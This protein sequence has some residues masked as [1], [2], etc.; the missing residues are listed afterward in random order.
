MAI[1]PLFIFKHKT[2]VQYLLCFIVACV[3]STVITAQPPFSFGIK[4]GKMTITASKNLTQKQIDS[5]SFKYKLSELK[6]DLLIKQNFTDSLKN[7]GW[8]VEKND[9]KW[10][11]LS[12]N[13]ESTEL[14]VGHGKEPFITPTLKNNNPFLFFNKYLLNRFKKNK[15]PT[16]TDTTITLTYKPVKTA[17]E[18][19]LAGSFTNW[20]RNAIPMVKQQNNEFSITVPLSKGKHTYKFIVDGEWTV[21]PLNEQVQDDGEGN[22]NSLLCKSNVSFYLPGYLKAK[23]VFLAG[24]FNNWQDQYI[25]LIKKDSGWF[26]NMYLIDGNYTYKFIVDDQWIEDPNNPMKYPNEFYG[27]YNSV[28]QIGTPTTFSLNGFLNAKKVTLLGSFNNFR[29]YEVVLEKNKEG[30]FTSYVIENG[31]H[32]YG[33]KVDNS[34][35]NQQGEIINNIEEGGTALVINANHSFTLKGFEKAKKI[36]VAGNFNGWKK[37]ATAMKFLNGVWSAEVYLPPGK[38]LYKFIVDGNWIKDP[39]N[40]LWE[41]NEYGDGN[42]IIWKE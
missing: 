33:F 41:G 25:K 17:K 8:I 3:C 36:Y 11:T 34:F 7:Q 21:D 20:Q 10:L 13:F 18:V 26:V 37:N 16:E 4:N 9:Y 30:W 22:Y 29:D 27:Q 24:S 2:S 32:I 1:K 28:K 19:L 14:Y 40:N 6:L 35:V 12:K 31:S 38:N 15:T 39:L 23:K 5:L 42:S